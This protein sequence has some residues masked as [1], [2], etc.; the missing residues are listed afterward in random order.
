MKAV[1]CMPVICDKIIYI[2]VISYPP[3][4]PW[5]TKWTYQ[6][7]TKETIPNMVAVFH[8][9]LLSIARFLKQEQICVNC[10]NTSE[11]S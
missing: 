5:K 7:V 3:P 10:K 4:S 1:A 9:L 11:R 2:T 6:L 8:N